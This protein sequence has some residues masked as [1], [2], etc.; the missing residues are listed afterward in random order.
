MYMEGR[1]EAGMKLAHHFLVSIFILQINHF[2]LQPLYCK[3]FSERGNR[4]LCVRASQNG[5]IPDAHVPAFVLVCDALIFLLLRDDPDDLGRALGDHRA[6][7]HDVLLKRGEVTFHAKVCAVVCYCTDLHGDLRGDLHG[8]LRGCV[9]GI[10]A[11]G[12]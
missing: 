1:D 9:H 11:G 6:T 10:S 3:G 7:I 5:L 12:F 4:R 2:V 8:D